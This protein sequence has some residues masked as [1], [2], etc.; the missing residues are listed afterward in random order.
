MIIKNRFYIGLAPRFLMEEDDGSAGPTTHSQSHVVASLN[1]GEGEGEGEGVPPPAAPVTPPAAPVFDPRALAETF[2]TVL[3]EHL[4]KPA[5]APQAPLTPEQIKELQQKL[6]YW[7]PDDA[8]MQKFGNL[9]T[10]R[11]AIVS[12]R[13]GLVRQIVTIMQHYVGDRE[14]NLRGEYQPLIQWREEQESQAREARFGQAYPQLANEA[15]KPVIYGVIAELNKTGTLKGKSEPEIFKA[16]ASG[17][18]AIIQVG[19]PD[20]KLAASAAAVQPKK[21]NPNSIP[22]T[23]P[24][25][26]GSGGQSA[27]GSKGKPKN[28]AL[29]HL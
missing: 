2:G 5:A 21:G 12:M 8:F 3:A 13:D 22:V 24:G 18:E 4:P 14:E 20:F 26:G 29:A 17:V 16:I 6:N 10:Q 27:A 7:E 11:E 1:A 25:A 28:F 15:L 19:T 23:T 9:D